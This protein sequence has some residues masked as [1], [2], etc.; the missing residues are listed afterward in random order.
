M[1]IA[2]AGTTAVW[3]QPEPALTGTN[4]ACL[5]NPNLA[6]TLTS[7][8]LS[9]MP[10]P[11]RD[12]GWSWLFDGKSLH[13]WWES[14]QSSHSSAD[15]TLGGIWLVDSVN[16]LLFSN[17]NTNGAGSLLITN[18]SYGNY[19]LILETWPSFGDDGGIFNRT[20]AA[21]SCYQTTMDY[22]QGSSVGGTYFEGGYTG[23]TRNFDP[24]VFGA[25]KYTITIGTNSNATN[26]WD[27]VTKKFSNPTQYG[28]PATGCGPAN[29]TAVW[30][31]GGWNQ[32]RVKFYGTGASTTNKVHNFAWIKKLAAAVW[33][34]TIL[35]SVQYNTPA[36]YVGFQIHGGTGSWSN[37]NG[38][39]MRNIKIRPLTDQGDPIISTTAITSGSK[40]HYDIHAT[41]SALVGTLASDHEIV[42]S[43]L[44]GRVLEKF[45]GHAG[46][47]HHAFTTQARGVML[48][49]VKTSKSTNYIRVTR[50]SE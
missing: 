38:N 45:S 18:K 15:R 2:L 44:S 28:C 1:V 4:A 12:S 36:S 5:A 3:A 13:G 46:A 14:C 42:V 34:P 20:T 27:S 32:V 29:W 30:D 17:Q 19:E 31:T 21:G 43:D 47:F 50:I 11:G 24:F 33:T 25:N 9:S 49:A 48:L 39:W 7:A 26:R 6:D 16:H 41:S 37:R 8:Q 10:D 22:I 23:T 35:D 40:V